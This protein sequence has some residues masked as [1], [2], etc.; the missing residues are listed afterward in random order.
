[1]IRTLGDQGSEWAGPEGAGHVTA[2]PVRAVDSTAAGD[3]FCGV[4]AAGLDRGET[5]QAAMRRA[6]VAA[7][8]CCM[9]SG[10]Q[11]SLPTAAQIGEA[12]RQPG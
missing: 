6:S 5:L 3:C 7:A 10:S 4:L 11:G 9:T 8:L 1:M 2:M 12:L